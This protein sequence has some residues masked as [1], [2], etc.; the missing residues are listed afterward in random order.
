VADYIAVNIS[1]P[2][3]KGLRD[4]QSEDA[5]RR[6]VDTL[7]REQAKLGL[8]HGKHVPVLVKIAPD[9]ENV[10]IEALARVFNELK[11]DGIIATNTTI[12]RAAVIGHRQ[13]QRHERLP[14]RRHVDAL[15][16]HRR[17]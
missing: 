11:V 15:R 13:S 3:T 17:R 10:Q 4:L 9:L 8:E 5:I 1:S 7:K 14:R 12:S 6:L 16:P 2:N